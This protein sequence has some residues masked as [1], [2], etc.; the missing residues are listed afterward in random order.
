MRKGKGDPEEFLNKLF[1]S[2]TRAR[3]LCILYALPGQSFYQR[4][5]MYETGLSLRPVQRELNNLLRLGIVKKQVT[6]NRVY[7]EIN[8]DSTFFKPLKALCGPLG[9]N[10]P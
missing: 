10:D 2:V 3:I 8:S 6:R 9:K 1:G 5:I 7:Y 4:E